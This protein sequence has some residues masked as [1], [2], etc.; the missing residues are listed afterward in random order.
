MQHP[1]TPLLQPHLQAPSTLHPASKD[2]SFLIPPPDSESKSKSKSKSKFKSTSTSI[3]TSPDPDLG[4]D[5][6]SRLRA[7]TQIPIRF[8][9][10]TQLTHLPFYLI[11]SS[12][13][14]L[15]NSNQNP[16]PN[17]PLHISSFRLGLSQLLRRPRR[18][19]NTL[20]TRSRILVLLLHPLLWTRPSTSRQAGLHKSH[21]S[22]SS[23]LGASTTTTTA[24]NDPP[25]RLPAPKTRTSTPHTA[26]TTP[27]ACNS[28]GICLLSQPRPRSLHCMALAPAPR[29]RS[30]QLFSS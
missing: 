5:P 23:W 2:Q 11:S 7:Q 8:P 15:H 21:Q 26:F 29:S 27:S 28:P 20:S 25:R 10:L 16:G 4:P 1:S 22:C 19:T 18:P 30:T 24:A 3:P 14:Q 9:S 12:A 6:A 13:P 17:A